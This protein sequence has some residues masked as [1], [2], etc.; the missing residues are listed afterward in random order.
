V[1]TGGAN[2]EHGVYHEFKPEEIDSADVIVVASDGI[3]DNLS[4]KTIYGLLEGQLLSNAAK[5][6]ADFAIRMG[7]AIDYESP[8]YLKAK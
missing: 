8:F 7:T 2:P 6:I 3:W 4:S 1:G 5:D